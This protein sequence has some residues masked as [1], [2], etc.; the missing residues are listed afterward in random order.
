MNAEILIL[1]AAFAV[2]C[3]PRSAPV[4]AHATQK[5]G[6]VGPRDVGPQQPETL[7]PA[8]N[9]FDIVNRFIDERFV[10]WADRGAS[11]LVK[12]PL[13]GGPPI[14]LVSGDEQPLTSLAADAS[15]LYFTTGRRTEPSRIWPAEEVPSS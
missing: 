15:S 6:K 7:A 12:V 9:D 10:Y 11:G 2:C 3:S 14:T 13:D 5:A 4:T 8:S 1:I